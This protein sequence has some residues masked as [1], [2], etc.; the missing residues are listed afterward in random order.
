MIE[1][2]FKGETIN[3]PSMLC[4][5]DAHV[6][7]DWVEKNGGCDGMRKRSQK[8]IRKARGSHIMSDSDAKI[9]KRH[10]LPNA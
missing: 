5:E 1:G 9:I 10:F 8:M 2:L 3:T 4:V 6:S 7:L